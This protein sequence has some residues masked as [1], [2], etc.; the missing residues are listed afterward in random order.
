MDFCYSKQSQK[1]I[2]L[3]VQPLKLL[4]YNYETKS[5]LVVY[6][7]DINIKIQHAT[8]SCASSHVYI[9]FDDN[10][11][12]TTKLPTEIKGE[13][14]D[15]IKFVLPVKILDGSANNIPRCIAAHPTVNEQYA[16]G[17]SNGNVYICKRGL[18]NTTDE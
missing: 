14:F 11:I 5:K 16:L 3:V 2:I 8:F 9:I 4:F 7:P 12:S 1:A 15:A 18:E 10:T 6:K 17:Y 13:T